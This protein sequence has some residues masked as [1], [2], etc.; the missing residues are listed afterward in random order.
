M[1]PNNIIHPILNFVYVYT[2]AVYI[3]LK[4]YLTKLL[5]I[6]IIG[7]Y[8]L[9]KGHTYTHITLK[10]TRV[11]TNNVQI[12][13]D[14]DINKVKQLPFKEIMEIVNANNGFFYNE[15]SKKKLNRYAREVSGRTVWRSPRKSTRSRKNSRVL[16]A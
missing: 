16:G 7:K 6:T 10:L 11:I 13:L 1:V 5:I 9:F 15:N 8:I 3:I 2:V 12:M 14:L 4:K